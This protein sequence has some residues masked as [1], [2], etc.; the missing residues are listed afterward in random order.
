MVAVGDQKALTRV[1]SSRVRIATGS[2]NSHAT[3][4]TCQSALRRKGVRCFLCRIRNDSSIGVDVLVLSVM[5]WKRSCAILPVDASVS[6]LDPDADV[7][8]AQVRTA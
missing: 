4:V 6:E 2:P 8:P 3:R 1:D 7:S 5:A